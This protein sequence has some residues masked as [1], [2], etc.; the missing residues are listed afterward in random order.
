MRHEHNPGP[1]SN[2][3]IRTLVGTVCAL[4]LACLFWGLH[5]GVG[6]AIADASPFIFWPL[7]AGL[8]LSISE[9]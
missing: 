7:A 1:P 3:G 5:S 4:G 8:G 9:S 6:S 2:I